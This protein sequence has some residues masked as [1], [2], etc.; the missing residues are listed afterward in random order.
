MV[1]GNLSSHVF[2]KEKKFNRFVF[3]YLPDL[4]FPDTCV[5]TG[6]KKRR[7]ERERARVKMPRSNPTKSKTG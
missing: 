3:S 2:R 5:Y 4:V 6:E 7:G 1:T